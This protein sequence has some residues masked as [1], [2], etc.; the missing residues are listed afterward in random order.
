MQIIFFMPTFI[1]GLAL[2]IEGDF[3][4]LIISA[5]SVLIWLLPSFWESREKAPEQ[6][7]PSSEWPTP[8]LGKLV[9]TDGSEFFWPTCSGVEPVSI[10]LNGADRENFFGS[11]VAACPEE[12]W[13]IGGEFDSAFMQQ[14]DAHQ[15]PEQLVR[16]VSA[17]IRRAEIPLP[18]NLVVMDLQSAYG[19]D[20]FADLFRNSKLSYRVFFSGSGKSASGL[21]VEQQQG[22]FRVWG[23]LSDKPVE[24]Y[25][26]DLS[27]SS[28]ETNQRGDERLSSG[29][30]FNHIG[31]ASGQHGTTRSNKS[32]WLD[33]P[34]RRAVVDEGQRGKAGTFSKN[35]IGHGS[36]SE[37]GGSDPIT[38]ITARLANL[39]H[40]IKPD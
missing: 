12:F 22:V 27:L 39:G 30:A 32:K 18:L 17:F 25:F 36:P 16:F 38:D 3:L 5:G 21:E 23:N 4:L 1:Y 8:I 24:F 35:Q 7:P 40:R 29:E 26:A 37:V 20:E 13:L 2:S 34:A 31:N 9:A 11:L 14:V 6:M 10:N 19:R 33:F 28:E 15:Q